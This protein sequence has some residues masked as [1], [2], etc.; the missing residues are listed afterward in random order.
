[1]SNYYYEGSDNVV[2]GTAVA[3]AQLD[4]LTIAQNVTVGSSNGSSGVTA[5]DSAHVNVAGSLISVGGAAFDAA[6]GGNRIVIG[7]TGTVS[8]GLAAMNIGDGFNHISNAGTIMGEAGIDISGNDNNLINS[9]QI[10]SSYLVCIQMDGGGN[11]IANS[12]SLMAADD[13]CISFSSSL[14]SDEFNTID[15]SGTISAGGNYAAFLGGNAPTDFINSGHVYG[16]IDFG[17]SADN[18]DGSLGSIA[19][20]VYGGGGDDTLTGGAGRDFLQG[21]PGLDLLE[22]GGGH[23]RFV[24]TAVVESNGQNHDTIADFD[25][26]RDVFDLTVAVTGIDATVT[27]GQLRAGHFAGDLVTALGPAQLLAHHAVLFTPDTGALKGHTILAVD[28]DGV[29]GFSN[30]ADYAFD[31]TNASN[32]GQL[33]TDDFV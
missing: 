27:S 22:G 20:T 32:L 29:A 1:M 16:D 5:T 13:T 21:G 3:L 33:G 23:D 15:N 19:G 26:R 6:G 12:G 2:A 18:Y 8:G 11:V 25:A 28:A 14:V 24:Y 7:A 31:I 4:F 10:L 30:T 17:N 9:G